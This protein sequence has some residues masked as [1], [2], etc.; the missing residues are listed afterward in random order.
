M[1]LSYTFNTFALYLAA[2]ETI[3][4]ELFDDI[5]EFDDDNLVIKVKTELG[6]N[7]IA[8]I[9]AGIDLDDKASDEDIC[10]DNR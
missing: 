7:A 5:C 3:K 4:E 10:Y 6:Y 2:K 9:L 8:N 1:N